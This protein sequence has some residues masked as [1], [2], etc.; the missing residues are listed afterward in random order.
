MR[1]TWR[2]F[3]EFDPISLPEVAQT[4]AHGIV[5]SLHG[6]PYGE[7]WSRDAIGARKQQIETA[8]FTWDVV[9]SLPVHEDIKRGEGNLAQLFSNY[10]QSLANLAAEGVTTVCYNFMPVLDWTRTDL[11][12][13]LPRGGTC[14][15]F[16]AG[17][18]AAFELLM[19]G[20]D[21]A[22]D[23]YSPAAIEAG[24]AWHAAST[25]D[26][27]ARLLHAIMSGLPGAVDTYT[28]NGLQ[29][30]LAS[31]A[32]IS[33]DDLRQNLRQFLGEVVPT[34]ADLG[35]NMCIHPDDPPR[36]LLGLPRVVS[37]EADI[38]MILS[39][40]N[41]PSNGLTFCTGSLGANSSNDLI[42]ILDRFADRVHFA[43]LRNITR[44]EDGSFEESEHLAGEVDLVP[45][46]RR[47]LQ[48]EARRG[49]SVPFRADH[50]HALLTDAQVDTQPGYTLIGRLKGLAE[51]RGIIAATDAA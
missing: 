23:D 36:D 6:V 11:F 47:L 15:R 10:R 44:F 37:T 43:H 18:M 26:E 29:D 17:K 51:L 27:R 35:V 4:G 30:V 20:R 16:D 40:V 41:Q 46:I 12:A 8:G 42:S 38:E 13:P 34:A 3:G 14:L 5:S 25:D 49:V 28:I 50:G 39:A 21:A 19:L 1:E 7:T 9:E 31:Y 24:N 32:G 22:A 2:W 33:H 45:V 48:S